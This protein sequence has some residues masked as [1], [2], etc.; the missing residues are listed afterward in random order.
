M[1]TLQYSLTKEDYANYYSYVLWDTP[2]KKLVRKKYYLRQLFINLFVVGI[3]SYSAIFS[4]LSNTY[5]FFFIAILIATSVY[6][7]L[8]QKYRIKAQAKKFANNEENA[9][10]F[11]SCYHQFSETGITLKD[12]VSLTQ[13]QWKAIVK[14]DE[15][16]DYYFLYTNSIQALIIP[17]RE[18]KNIEEQNSFN[19]LLQLHI[20][21]NAEVGH[22]L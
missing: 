1:I 17:K 8:N 4:F 5:I 14:K 21:F 7:F 6:N 13:L 22:L 16:A 10:I 18:F 15:N 3:A 11:F 19:Q 12:E 9:S 2:E 20:S